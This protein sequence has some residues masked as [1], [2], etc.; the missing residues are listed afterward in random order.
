MG[1][2]LLSSELAIPNELAIPG[3]A[4]RREGN[5]PSLS[6]GPGSVG[7]AV[8]QTAVL[9]LRFGT[10]RGQIWLR[11]SPQLTTQIAEKPH[12]H[13]VSRWSGGGGI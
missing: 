5:P 3:P 12:N 11:L 1:A 9:V 8:E 4:E 10:K 6:E 7:A 2:G 13:A